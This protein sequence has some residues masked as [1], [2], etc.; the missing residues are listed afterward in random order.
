MEIVVSW[1]EDIIEEI[2]RSIADESQPSKENKSKWSASNVS[3]KSKNPN[4]EQ[5]FRY[6][7][8]EN[9]AALISDI[10]K[11]TFIEDFWSVP[12]RYNNIPEEVADDDQNTKSK[13]EWMNM[14]EHES[15]MS[16]RK[17]TNITKAQTDFLQK[18]LNR[19]PEQEK[20]ICL[21]YKVSIFTYQRLKKRKQQNA[22]NCKSKES[23]WISEEVLSDNMKLFVENYWLLLNLPWI[24]GKLGD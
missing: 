9:K 19:H 5:D 4:W 23:I 2:Q 24:W 8:E 20:L 15:L 7:F 17:G 11:L 3:T 18:I 12:L 21:M 1:S 16:R 14:R 6:L 22:G 10:D 13:F